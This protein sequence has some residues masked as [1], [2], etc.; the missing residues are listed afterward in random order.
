V[1]QNFREGRQIEG[2]ECLRL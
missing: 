2:Q 1:E